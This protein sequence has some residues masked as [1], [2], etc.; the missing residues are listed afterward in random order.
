[1]KYIKTSFGILLAL[2]VLLVSGFA[3]VSAAPVGVVWTTSS[4]ASSPIDIEFEM[5]ETVYIFWTINDT[6]VNVDIEI[7]DNDGNNLAWV[8]TN[9]A[10]SNQPVTWVTNSE[11]RFYV[12]VY[13][14]ETGAQIGTTYLICASTFNVTVVPESMLGAVAAIGAAFGAFGLVKY[15]KIKI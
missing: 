1:M 14:H 12:N 6:S 8:A 2:S 15:R 5:G 9:R 11:G 7:T 10:Y 13:E 3:S 4:G